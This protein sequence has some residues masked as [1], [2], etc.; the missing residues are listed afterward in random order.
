MEPGTKRMHRGLSEGDGTGR[1]CDAGGERMRR[2]SAG[3]FF[4]DRLLSVSVVTVL[5]VAT[6]GALLRAS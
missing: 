5:R 3:V 1:R 6:E 4:T 2:A